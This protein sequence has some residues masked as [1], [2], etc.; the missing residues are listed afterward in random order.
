MIFN[1]IKYIMIQKCEHPPLLPSAQSRVETVG[2]GKVG[3]LAPEFIMI[4]NSSRI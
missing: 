1:D 2:S 3:A 4:I